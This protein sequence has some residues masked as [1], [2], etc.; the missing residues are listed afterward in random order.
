[1]PL[2]A[3]ANAGIE[4]DASF[5]ER[6]L[7]SPITLG[8]VAGYV[9]GKPLGIVGMSWIA[10]RA[11]GHRLHPPVGWAAVAGGG[12]IAGIGFT[13]SLLVATLAFSGPDLD[14]AKFGIL[15][16]ALCAALVTWLLFTVVSL[17]PERVRNRAMHG[18][19]DL[20]TD[21]AVEVDPDRDHVRGPHEAAVTLLEYG[22]LE[23]P[24][25]G[26][27]EDT[28]RELL[29]DFSDL[30]YVWRHLPL[31]E[32]HPHAELAAEASEAA[33]E[34]GEF[35]EMHDLL[36]E[37]QDALLFD[38]LVR[39]AGELGLDVERFTEYLDARRGAV[40]VAEDIESAELS[41]VSGTPTFFINGHRHHGPYDIE[42]LSGAVRAA[43]ARE[44]VGRDS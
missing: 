38:D 35:W 29:G 2:F 6:A 12:T 26:R 25:C 40:R 34:Q 19:P 18:N 37:R 10:A 15:G 23:C 42:T 17:W 3:L 1:M 8:I 22:D 20:L 28:I 41:E 43:G 27:A 39:H 4:I 31:T 11:S 30:R 24:Y 16:A 7:K 33:H 9:I 44:N 14:E 32:V 5:L 36:F 21:L 13:V